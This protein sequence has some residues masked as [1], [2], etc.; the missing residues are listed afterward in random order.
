[1]TFNNLIVSVHEAFSVTKKD[2]FKQVISH[3]K[4]EDS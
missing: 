3:T 1:M 4:F 2:S